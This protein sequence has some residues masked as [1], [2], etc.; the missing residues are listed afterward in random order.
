MRIA[1]TGI[2][3]VTPVG[4]NSEETW[5]NL[6]RGHSGIGPLSTFEASTF[7]ARI[8][9][10]VRDLDVSSVK[11]S[12]C[13]FQYL[14]RAG[15][16]GA[17]AANEAIKQAA[18]SPDTHPPELRGVFGGGHMARPSAEEFSSIIYDYELLMQPHARRDLMTV[19]R[20]SQTTDLAVLARQFCSAGPLLGL[21]TACASSAHAIG[22]AFTRIQAGE[23]TAAL[24]GGHDSLLSWLDLA[25]FSLLDALT[26]S[27]NDAPSKGSR[28]FSADRDGFV[29][30]EGAAYVIL[31]RADIATERGANIL[32][33]IDGYASS[34]NAYSITDA[35]PGGGETITA[36]SKA[37][38]KANLTIEDVSGVYAH[39]TG[40][41][42]N[43]SSESA[44]IRTLFAQHTDD[45]F[46]TSTKSAT[47][48]LTA[49][50]GSLNVV[51]ATLSFRDAV[52]PPTINLEAKDPE[53]KIPVVQN[54]AL[55]RKS[56]SVVVNAF[57][58][59]G[60]NASLVMSRA[61]T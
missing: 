37:L 41:P 52:V 29:L 12:E 14:S 21:S 60:T 10:Q 30:G 54:A 5:Q 35:P 36:M 61:D 58:F 46:V 22:E 48:H 16:F 44:A 39:G 31:E 33:Y 19:K 3:A 6:L 57:A 28:P 8:A 25:G 49:A 20:E 24:A 59:G 2:G 51:A 27:Y 4:N 11:N 45:L 47:G 50:A 1:V 32:A 9:G 26:T 15:T 34:M 43:D 23:I 38:N 40:T 55:P 42:G 53:L 56:K 17:V 13:S 7:P 18:L